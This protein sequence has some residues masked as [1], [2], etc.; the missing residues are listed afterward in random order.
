MNFARSALI[1]L[2]VLLLVAGGY[3]AF[4]SFQR[5]AAVAKEEI[6]K[7]DY[8]QAVAEAERARFQ[9]LI[10]AVILFPL[11]AWLL[12]LAGLPPQSIP[13]NVIAGLLSFVLVFTAF[14]HYMEQ[15]FQARYA[16]ASLP[17]SSVTLSAQFAIAG[18]VLSLI[19]FFA[20]ERWNVWR[21]AR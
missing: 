5:S 10:A 11:T 16:R 19:V 4:Y 20:L 7:P 8:Q 2:V 3:F 14:S 13:R 9:E 1:V 18:I 15:Q 17:L 12:A 6:E 21:L